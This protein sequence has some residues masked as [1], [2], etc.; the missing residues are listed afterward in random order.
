MRQAAIL[1]FGLIL[2][3]ILPMV[4]AAQNDQVLAIARVND[5]DGSMKTKM[6]AVVT[7]KVEQVHARELF[8]ILENKTG[9]KFVYDKSILSYPHTF[10]MNESGVSVYDLLYRISSISDYRFKQV[11]GNIHVR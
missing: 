3:T 9:F 2:Q 10:S 7:L 6:D 4:C 11:N 8:K 1:M 5:Q